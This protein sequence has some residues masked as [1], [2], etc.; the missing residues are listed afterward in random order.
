MDHV[1]HVSIIGMISSLGLGDPYTSALGLAEAALASRSNCVEVLS[2]ACK[3]KRFMTEHS[4]SHTTSSPT[5]G[6]ENKSNRSFNAR[7]CFPPHL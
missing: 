1:V 5:C 2:A 3:L 7:E 6:K 4:G